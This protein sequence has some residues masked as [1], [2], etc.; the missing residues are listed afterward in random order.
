MAELISRVPQAIAIIHRGSGE[1]VSRAAITIQDKAKQLL[2]RPGTGRIYGKHQASAPGQP[3][4]VQT[5]FLRRSVQVD[6]RAIKNQNPRARV[7]TFIP[8][9]KHLEFGTLNIARRPWL[10]RARRES[11]S[12]IEQVVR[13]TIR[14]I[15]AELRLLLRGS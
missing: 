6:L 15:Q 2:S 12:K 14:D 9:G 8:Y 11:R 3:P 13:K 1:M 5:G 10:S 4:T 7:G